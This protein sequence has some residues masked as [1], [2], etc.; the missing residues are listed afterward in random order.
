MD[1]KGSSCFL[2]FILVICILVVIY[3]NVGVE[4]KSKEELDNAR[5]AEVPNSMVIISSDDLYNSL[6]NG[7]KTIA[8]NAN[9]EVRNIYRALTVKDYNED[10]SKENESSEENLNSTL[11]KETTTE[12]TKI[13]AKNFVKKIMDGS[14][15][16][17]AIKDSNKVENEELVF[18]SINEEQN[19]IIEQENVINEEDVIE[20]K[21]VT[22]E[23]ASTPFIEEQT[24]SLA[25]MEEQSGNASDVE[26]QNTNLEASEQAVLN[27]PPTNYVKTLDMTATAYCL[28]QKCCGKSP[29]SPGYGRTASGLVIVPNTGM[30]VIAVD[31]KVIPLGTKVY[32]QGLNG[33]W[34]YGYA[35]AADT[36]GAI[37]QNKIDLYHDSHQ[38]ALKWGRRSVRVYILG[39]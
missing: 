37:K 6:V 5:L 22:H 15:I 33:A 30:K 8:E 23:F 3:T 16:K 24:K 19:I 1:N 4:I 7:G 13:G 36:G 38:D 21:A 20:L 14:L 2:S 39:E 32:V 31:P 11:N 29:S 17:E 35:I 28:C 26:A 34:D 27:G 10:T 25:I 12:K 9:I 18:N